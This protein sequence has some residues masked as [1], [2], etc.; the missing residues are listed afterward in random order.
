MPP[1]N[2]VIMRAFR[3]LT[4][5]EFSARGDIVR[6]I[7]RARMAKLTS[8]GRAMDG[9]RENVALLGIKTDSGTRPRLLFGEK[10]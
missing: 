5:S 3:R 4:R 8:E 9:L 10:S 1:M 2:G 6:G 7:S